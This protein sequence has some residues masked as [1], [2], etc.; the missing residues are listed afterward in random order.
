MI[1]ILTA[2]FFLAFSMVIW[3]GFWLYANALIYLGCRGFIAKNIISFIVY[4]LFACFLVTP[5]FIALSLDSWREAQNS[6]L[7]YMLYLG[8][9]FI[10]S[11]IPG[12]LHFKNNYLNIL[13]NLGYFTKRNK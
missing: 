8:M 1:W 13:R 6:N 11:I 5:L 7:Y 3:V 12:G 4:I 10:F 2:G 9:C